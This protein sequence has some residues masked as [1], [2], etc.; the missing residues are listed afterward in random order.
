MG[1]V[2]PIRRKGAGG[3][4]TAG[5]YIDT[6]SYVLLMETLIGYMELRIAE[7]DAGRLADELER[8]NDQ[9]RALAERFTPPMG[10]A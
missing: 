4:P 1:K 6:A 3:P 8:L 7:G 10:A 5:A 9:L 2:T